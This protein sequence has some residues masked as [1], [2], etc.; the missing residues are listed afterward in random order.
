MAI[1]E[2]YKGPNLELGLNIKKVIVFDMDGV[3]FDTPQMV[4]EFFMQTYPNLTKEIMDKILSGNFHEELEK[5][6]KTNS[7][8]S[9]TPEEHQARA[10]A[11]SAKKLQS[12]LYDG[13]FK[14]LEKLHSSRYTLVMNT[15]AIERNTLPLLEYSNTLKFFD[16]VATAETSKSK[17]EKFQIISDKYHVPKPKMIFITDT[18]GDLRE[19]DVAGVP[20]IAVTWGAHTCEHFIS[21]PHANLIKVVD[22]VKELES[23]L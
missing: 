3:L 5:F 19:A 11:Y 14:L 15:S 13:I 2:T 8:I 1:I 12:P 21:E 22:S 17:V 9:E 10:A 18:L 7:P 23:L 4:N 20:T 16:F 6:K